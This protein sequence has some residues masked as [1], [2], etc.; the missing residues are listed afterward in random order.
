[1][2]PETGREEEQERPSVIT[3]VRDTG[4]SIRAVPGLVLLFGMTLFVGMWS[5]SFDRLWGDFF[6]V[7]IHFPGALTSGEWFSVLGAAVAVIGLGT[8][9]LAKRRTERQGPGPVTGILSTLLVV[10]AACVG[11]MALAHT[12]GLALAGYLVVAAIRPVYEP[13]VSGWMVKKVD[14]S[15]RA[16]A[17]SAR[18]MCDSGGQI[19]GGPV[20]GAIGLW[21]SVRVALL[22]GAG[23]AVRAEGPGSVTVS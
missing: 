7:D 1:V 2:M 12:F 11:I 6:I 5:E 20:F 19:A 9:E 14:E 22:A 13:L 23:Q 16:T 4:R 10:S 18:E 21:V 8:T 3:Q 17:L 15:V